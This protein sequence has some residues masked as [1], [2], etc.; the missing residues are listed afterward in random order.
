MTNSPSFSPWAEPKNVELLRKWWGDEGLPASRISANFQKLGLAIT[1]NAIIGKVHRE[2][3]LPPKWKKA[4]QSD[5]KKQRV[6]IANKKRAK[7]PVVRFV[8]INGKRF[9]PSHK[10]ITMTQGSQNSSRSVLLKDTKEGECRAIIGYQ[11]GQA[12]L[13]VCCGKP[14]VLARRNGGVVMTSWCADHHAKY[15]MEAKR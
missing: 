10:E 8:L 2:K 4:V 12:A 7:E 13:A 14:T 6:S 9:H 15:T 3:I 5:A 11:N 1:K